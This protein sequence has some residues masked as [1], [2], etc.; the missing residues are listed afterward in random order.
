M[1]NDTTH[2]QYLEEQKAYSKSI[3]KDCDFNYIISDEEGV[4]QFCPVMDIYEN[5]MLRKRHCEHYRVDNK[6]RKV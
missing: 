2:K 6:Y 4:M 3:C 1:R 5:E